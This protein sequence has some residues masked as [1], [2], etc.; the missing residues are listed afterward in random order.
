MDDS[1]YGAATE[2]FPT[3]A[4]IR[5]G[6]SPA[7]SV[8][9]TGGM[10]TLGALMFLAAA[11]ILPLVSTTVGQPGPVTVKSCE[12]AYIDSTGTVITSG[13]DGIQYTNGVTLTA[14]NASS[15]PISGFTVS[16]NYN[17]FKVTD[18]WA[19]TLPPGATL[20]VW[21]HYQR[22]PYSGPKAECHIINVTFA[23]GTTWAAK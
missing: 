10:E 6:D 13:V 1:P 9:C 21:K 3:L 4:L 7:V 18:T 2:H 5:L 23:D 12:V 15:K 17:G 20:S 14:Q 11:T 8:C 22:L 16:G 19:G